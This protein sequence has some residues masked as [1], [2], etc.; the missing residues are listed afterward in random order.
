M[1]KTKKQVRKKGV[2]VSA[3][4]ERTIRSAMDRLVAGETTIV[5][6][7]APLTAMNL[8]RESGVPR[9]TVYRSKTLKVFQRK[10]D[11]LRA[12]Q[13]EAPA[14]VI[15]RLQQELKAQGA[16][17]KDRIRQLE[18]RVQAYAQQINFLLG[19]RRAAEAGKVVPISRG[20]TR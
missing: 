5:R 14:L 11:E 10:V 20:A 15:E 2:A 8:V 1:P 16:E 3:E 17:S 12:A 9:A 19:E 4:K 13:G 7:G 6:R 18:E